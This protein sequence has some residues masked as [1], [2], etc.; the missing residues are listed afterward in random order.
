MDDRAG[1]A[2]LHHCLQMLQ[3]MHHRWDVTLSP[4]C[5]NGPAGAMTSATASPHAAIAV[6]VLRRTPDVSGVQAVDADKG[7]R[8]QG[9]QRT[10]S[11]RLVETAQK[12]EIPIQ[13]GPFPGAAAPM[14]GL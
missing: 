2:A 10:P 5:G 8:G 14:P 4:P 9:P 12:H 6:D 11:E 13:Y 3:N 7:R 1:V